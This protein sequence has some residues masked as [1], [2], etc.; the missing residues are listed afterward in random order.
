MS[1][2]ILHVRNSYGGDGGGGDVNAINSV[3]FRVLQ[4]LLQLS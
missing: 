1:H 3:Y 4:G 2:L